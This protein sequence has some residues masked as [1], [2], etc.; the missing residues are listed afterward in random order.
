ML[1]TQERSEHKAKNPYFEENQSSEYIPNA[2]FVDSDPTV[3][4]AL[5]IDSFFKSKIGLK[6]AIYDTSGRSTGGNFF[7]ANLTSGRDTSNK[8]L[9]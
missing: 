1:E 4:D 6:R 3:T 2:L 7:A 9:E 8:V 5:K